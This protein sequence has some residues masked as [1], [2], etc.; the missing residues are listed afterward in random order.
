MDTISI[1]LIALGL[2]ADCFAVSLS[3]SVLK[4]YNAIQIARTAITFGVFQF[5]MPV[6]GW[7][8]GR[9]IVDII[10][11]FDHWIA[12]GLLAL[13]GGRMIW[14]YFK[15]KEEQE[16]TDISKGVLL[17]TLGFATS[18]DALAVG[19]GFAFLNINIWF[20]CIVIG[21]VAIGITLIGFVIGRK[22]GPLL[23]KWAKLAGGL[24]LIGI[25]LRILITHLLEK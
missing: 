11:E 12:F 16:K 15:E 13:I 19:L 25:G 8:L 20:A 21:I 22:A 23:G 24:I 18:I 14:E 1:I 17:L 10:S 7:L 4:K 9:T 5:S 6:I 3:G 2:A